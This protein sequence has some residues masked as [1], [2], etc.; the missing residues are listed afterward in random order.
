MRSIFSSSKG[1]NEEIVLRLLEPLA[2]TCAC[3]S[4]IEYVEGV[5]SAKHARDIIVYLPKKKIKQDDVFPQIGQ[6]FP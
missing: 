2:V 1:E 5:S 6:Q 3:G 4:S